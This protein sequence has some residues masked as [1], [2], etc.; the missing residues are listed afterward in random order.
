[1]NSRRRVGDR[2]I[3]PGGDAAVSH[4]DRLIE[5]AQENVGIGEQIG[6]VDVARIEVDRSGE[7]AFSFF[8][9]P[10]PPMQVS[11][12]REQRNAVGHRRFGERQ[13]LLGLLIFALASKIMI[14]HREMGVGRIRRE[15]QRR[16]GCDSPP[17]R[18]CCGCV[19]VEKVK[20][21]VRTGGVGVGQH[22]I[23]IARGGLVQQPDRF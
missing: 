17:G 22:E 3:E 23:G 2:K 6:G 1:M 19:E 14:S 4:G 13:L 5:L 18:A 10:F 9:L 16:L 11:R 12:E 15:A 7:I 21:V 20:Q 8:P